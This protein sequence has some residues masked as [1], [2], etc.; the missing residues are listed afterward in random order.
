MVHPSCADSCRSI[1]PRC[2][3]SEWRASQGRKPS[4]IQSGRA[5]ARLVAR[6]RRTGDHGYR[7]R[8]S[9]RYPRLK[10]GFLHPTAESTR[11]RT[12]DPVYV[13][14]LPYSK[15]RKVFPDIPSDKTQTLYC[16]RVYVITQFFSQLLPP[17]SENAC[18]NRDESAMPGNIGTTSLENMR[19]EVD[20]PEFPRLALLCRHA[21]SLKCLHELDHYGGLGDVETV[22]A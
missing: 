5:E 10:I 20:H 14:P 18:S 13:S 22:A 21:L 19:A 6:H 2:L 7:R 16:Y 4:L 12:Y 3:H 15:R 8:W 1:S 17:S 9:L 11:R